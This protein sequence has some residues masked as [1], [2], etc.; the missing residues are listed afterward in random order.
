M[1]NTKQKKAITKQEKQAVELVKLVNKKYR[2]T[3]K[4]LAYE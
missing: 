3:M 1:K 2:N 4:K